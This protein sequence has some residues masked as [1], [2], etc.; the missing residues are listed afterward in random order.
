MSTKTLVINLTRTTIFVDVRH[1]DDR[2]DAVQIQQRGRVHLGAG[3]RVDSRWL[4]HN[5]NVIDV[6]VPQEAKAVERPE[7]AAVNGDLP[8]V[9]QIET[10][11][12]DDEEGN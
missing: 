2:K 10:Q 5:P 9:T 7:I 1:A 3:Q 12:N 11:I 8:D 4:Q 6:H